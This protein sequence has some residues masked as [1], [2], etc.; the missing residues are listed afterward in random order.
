M[1]KGKRPK[2]ECEVCGEK[3]KSTLHRHHIVE[4]TEAHTDNHDMNLAIVCANCHSKI[5]SGDLEIIG[6]FPGTRPPTGRI[7]IYKL[8]GICNVPGMEDA[9]AYYKPKPK[10]MKVFYAEDKKE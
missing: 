8:N 7:L 4:Q 2:I 9:V 1:I 6:V 3:N 10:S 5:H